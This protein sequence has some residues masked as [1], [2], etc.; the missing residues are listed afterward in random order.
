M[1]LSDRSK[2]SCRNGK[3]S[4][5]WISSITHYIF[6]SEAQVI[7][8]I[9]VLLL[10]ST[11]TL[12]AIQNPKKLGHHYNSNNL[13][14]QTHT[15]PLEARDVMH[16]PTDFQSHSTGHNGTTLAWDHPYNS[17]QKFNYQIYRNQIL[18]TELPS[19][20]KTFTDSYLQPSQNY[21]YEIYAVDEN[22]WR[23]SSKKI[24]VQTKKNF[25]P[26][27]QQTANS[28]ELYRNTQLNTQIHT[29]FASDPNK[30]P[31]S[32]KLK[33]QDREFFSIDAQSGILVNKKYLVRDKEYKLNIQVTDGTSFVET[34]FSIKT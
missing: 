13:N 30:D 10:I 33:G 16:S 14:E 24:N 3:Q 31:L 18:L 23:S 32:Y 4:F 17:A 22:G 27:M 21:M 2:N 29:F 19:S 25:A 1:K 34:P 11:S 26:I 8:K 15:R 5:P 6:Y 20:Q 9:I 12:Y 28:I 7:F